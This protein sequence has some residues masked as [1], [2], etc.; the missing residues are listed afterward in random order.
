M[1][2]ITDTDRINE[3]ESMAEPFP[4]RDWRVEI[5][6]PFGVWIDS[7][8]GHNENPRTLRDA[9]DTRI[10]ARRHREWKA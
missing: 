2:A 4:R 1:S 10:L 5:R 6:L 3:L 8:N 9:I 7:V